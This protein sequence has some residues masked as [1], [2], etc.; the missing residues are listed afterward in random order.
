MLCNSQNAKAQD[1]TGAR[2]PD[3]TLRAQVARLEAVLRLRAQVARLVRSYPLLDFGIIRAQL[4]RLV[5][6]LA[7]RAQLARLVRSHPRAWCM[8][9]LPFVLMFRQPA[10]Y[11]N[12]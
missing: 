8:F 12:T 11:F 10:T 6:V 2:L 7:L 4:A 3:L 5:A 9:V 1:T